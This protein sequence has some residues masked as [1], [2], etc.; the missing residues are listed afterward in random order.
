MDQDF[1]E[2]SFKQADGHGYM[3]GR[4]Y[5]AASRL[6][7]QHYLW[8]EALGFNIHPSVQLPEDPVIAELAVGTGIWMT[9]VAREHPTAQLDGFDIDLSQAP[10]P[11]WLPVN[12]KLRQWNMLEDV[13]SELVGKYDLVHT[14]LLVLVVS[15]IDTTPFL[16]NLLKLLKPGGYLQWDELDCVN[17]RVKYADP[18]VP[19][20]ALEA[21]VVSTYSE[22][23]HNWVL[24]IPRLLT[25]AG[26]QEAKLEYYDDIRELARHHNDQHL[27][28]FEEFAN[29][30]TK[31]NKPEAAAKFYQLINDG[32]QESLRGATLCKPRVVSIARKPI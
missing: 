27:L 23:R 29:E 1:S 32:Y 30:L 11:N 25:E 3:L 12:V 9:D 7:L 22:G 24:D 28:T 18:S 17:M 6:N 21:L 4:S 5:A 31:I 14:R 8:K 13:P 15:G 16:R 2:A 20:P 19:A 26:F 10:H